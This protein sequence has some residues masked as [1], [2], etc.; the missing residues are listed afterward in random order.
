MHVNTENEKLLAKGLAERIGEPNESVLT[1]KVGDKATTIKKAL[2]DHAEALEL[3][4]DFS[5]MLSENIHN[6]NDQLEEL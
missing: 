5:E 2:N 3:V 4:E 1:H 6:E